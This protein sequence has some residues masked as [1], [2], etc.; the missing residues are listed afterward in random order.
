MK[1]VIAF[2]LVAALAGGAHA[3]DVYK[4]KDGKGVVHYGDRPAAGASAALVSVRDDQPDPDDVARAQQRLSEVQDQR[5][6][7]TPADEPEAA[8]PSAPRPKAP[9]AAGSC[10]WKWQIY[11][12]SQGCFDQHRVAGGKG[13]T[14]NGARV[15]PQIV[16]PDCPQQ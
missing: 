9:P 8:R 13:V 7:D 16:Q 4:W 15:C 5:Q 12:Q 3:L 2:A 14:R 6:V 10:A 1:P 11:M